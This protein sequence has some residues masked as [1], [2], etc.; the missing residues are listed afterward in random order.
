MT[1]MLRRLE[2]ASWRL[3]EFPITSRDYGFQQGQARHRFIFRDDE[4]VESI[5]RENPTYRY[6]IPFREDLARGRWQNLFTVVYPQF[7]EACQDRSRGVL[8]DP[9]H[10]SIKA[11]CVSLREVMDIAG[12]RDGIDVEAEFIYAPEQSDLPPDLT[13]SIDTVQ[14]AEGMAGALDREI[15]VI[16]WQGE[17]PPEPTKDPFSFIASIGDQVEGAQNKITAKLHDAAFRAEKAAA[18]IDKLK[19]PRLAPVRQAARRVQAAAVGLLESG[20]Q[21]GKRGAR[22]M[23]TLRVPFA[24][25][26]LALA[27]KLGVSTA[28]LLRMNPGLSRSPRVEAGTLVTYY[29]RE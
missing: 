24:T 23:R 6:T 9:I 15:D 25:T 18:A 12:R 28:E 3:I 26:V 19:N 20:L 4:I 2:V 29:T 17:P 13:H 16:H 27:A 5:G 21:N 22:V 14:G 10:S 8:S 1:D 11:K 7:L